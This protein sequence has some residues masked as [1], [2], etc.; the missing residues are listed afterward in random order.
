MLQDAA[1]PHDD[2]DEHDAAVVQPAAA[3]TEATLIGITTLPVFTPTSYQE[4][5][6]APGVHAAM[7]GKLL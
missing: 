6:M 3:E 5:L 4:C 7:Q 1:D 2:A